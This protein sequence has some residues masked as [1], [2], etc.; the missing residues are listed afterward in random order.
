MKILYQGS[1][2]AYSELAALEVYPKM[3]AIS[4]IHEEAD[5]NVWDTDYDIFM[6]GFICD[7]P[8]VSE[9]YTQKFAHLYMHAYIH[10]YMHRCLHTCMQAS[11]HTNTHTHT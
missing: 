3:E 5:I 9:F 7:D 8:P 6:E 4:W 10:T 1:E 2:G 11:R